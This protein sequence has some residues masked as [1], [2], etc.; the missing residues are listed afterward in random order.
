VFCVF[1]F[2]LGFSHFLINRNKMLRGLLG[3]F[4]PNLV[5]SP[6]AQPS[7]PPASSEALH[8][9]KMGLSVFD[10]FRHAQRNALRF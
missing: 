5:F 3:M 8:N 6:L 1:G 9:V 4:R 10:S 7:L 2:T